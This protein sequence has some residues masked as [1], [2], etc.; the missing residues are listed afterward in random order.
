MGFGLIARL[1]E[2]FQN[3]DIVELTAI[4]AK[5]NEVKMVDLNRDQMNE[6]VASTGDFIRPDYTPFTVAQKR[7]K[8]QRYDVVT[9]RDTGAFQDNMYQTISGSQYDFFSRDSKAVDLH[10]KYAPEIFGLTPDSRKKAWNEFL[11]NSVRS[12]INTKL[13]S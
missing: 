1:N 11:A 12:Q 10:T 3:L 8:G 2:V 6:G 4:A 7:L 13:Q 9:L 5:E